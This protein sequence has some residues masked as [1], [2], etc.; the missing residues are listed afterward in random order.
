MATLS[1]IRE[2]VRA[3]AD[4]QNDGNHI[5]DSEVDGFI[6]DSIRLLHSL[7]VDGTDGQLFAKN[8]PVLAKLGTHSYQLPSDFSQLVSVDIRVQNWYVRSVAA[9]PQDYAQLSD[10]EDYGNWTPRRHFLRWNLEQA[11]G[12]L[13]IFPTPTATSDVAVQYIPSAPQLSLDSDTLEWPDFWHQWVVFDAAIQ[14]VNKSDE[15]MKGNAL[16]IERDRVEK[17]IRDHIRSMSVTR[18]KTIRPWSY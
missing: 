16:Q 12:E 10:Q 3:K 8:A 7:L 9:D 11:R 14:C 17:R 18:I 13:F 2:Q 4:I 1:T 5:S 6:N 15:G